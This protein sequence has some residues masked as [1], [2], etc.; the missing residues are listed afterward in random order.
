MVFLQ[1]AVKQL[2]VDT[3][4]QLEQSQQIEE[5]HNEIQTLKE[6]VR[7]DRTSKANQH[8]CLRF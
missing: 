1:A 8:N 3:T 6:Q 4:I 2:S 7:G 5:S